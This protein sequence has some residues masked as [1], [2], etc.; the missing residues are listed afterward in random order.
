MNALT[1]ISEATRTPPTPG[2]PA[3]PFRRGRLAK[4]SHPTLASLLTVAG[5]L[6]GTLREWLRGECELTLG[7]F[8]AVCDDVHGDWERC[9]RELRGICADCNRWRRLD[10]FGNCEVCKSGSI[11]NRRLRR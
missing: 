2:T 8:C 7:R 3:Q 1:P 4:L 11:T 9:P 5:G 6:A 10:R